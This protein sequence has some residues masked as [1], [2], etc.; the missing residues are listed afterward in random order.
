MGSLGSAYGEQWVDE[1]N[2]AL[3]VQDEIH[4]LIHRGIFFTAFYYDADID[5]AAIEDILIQVTS[6]I[7]LRLHVSVT[8]D[9][10]ILLYE[11]TTFSAAG[12]ANVI[13]SNRN[14]FSSNVT[15]AV[16]TTGP[17]VTLPGTQIGWA[18]I[19]GGSH[20]QAAGSNLGSFQ[21]WILPAGNYLM[22]ITNVSGGANESYSINADFYQPNLS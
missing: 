21:E 10:T 8:A 20:H 4:T 22:R 14:R 1:T 9:M 16:F 7:H 17:T 18:L 12:T 6:P 13:V 11:D 5:A 3:I 2:K 19:P 15:D